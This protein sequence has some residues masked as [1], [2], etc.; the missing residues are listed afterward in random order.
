MFLLVNNSR[1]YSKSGA[2]LLL[3]FDSG[4]SSAFF[5]ARKYN[6]GVVFD[7]KFAGLDKNY[8]L[9]NPNFV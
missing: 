7:D 5:F 3:F 6:I 8:Y 2:K 1:F 4:N 9:C